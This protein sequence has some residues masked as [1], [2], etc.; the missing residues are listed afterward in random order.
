MI[1]DRP[2]GL[3]GAC[4]RRPSQSDELAGPTAIHATNPYP[5]ALSLRIK[6]EGLFSN[7]LEWKYLLW[8]VRVSAN[9]EIHAIAASQ[10]PA[11]ITEPRLRFWWDFSGRTPHSNP[12]INPKRLSSLSRIVSI[13]TSLA[14]CVLLFNLFSH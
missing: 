3:L 2:L 11:E 10:A 7:R 13:R 5:Q 6:G 14:L 8:I 4:S 12:K 1:M 9:L